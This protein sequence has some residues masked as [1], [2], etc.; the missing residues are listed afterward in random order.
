MPG[1]FR[2]G[3]SIMA[4]RKLESFLGRRPMAVML[5]LGSRV[6]SKHIF[7]TVGLPQRKLSSFSWSIKNNLALKTLGIYSILCE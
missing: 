7:K 5:C 4:Q 2:V 6:V 3:L 1:V